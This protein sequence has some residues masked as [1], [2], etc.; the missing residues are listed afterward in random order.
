MTRKLNP[1]EILIFSRM[2][3]R[4]LLISS[5]SLRLPEA[6]RGL[7]SGKNTI[8]ELDNQTMNEVILEKVGT[9]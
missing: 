6:Y 8:I 7:F 3:S 1:F 9:N 2:L 4:E 5:F